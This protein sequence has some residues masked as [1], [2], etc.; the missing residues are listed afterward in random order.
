MQRVTHQGW[1]GASSAKRWL[2]ATG[3]LAL[4]VWAAPA[5][6]GEAVR[7]LVALVGD[8]QRTMF[9][10]R[11]LLREQ[12]DAAREALMRAVAAA[13]PRLLVILGDAVDKGDEES[14]WRYF[15]RVVAPVRERGTPIA[16][17]LGN[18]EYFG[19]VARMT[20]AVAARFAPFGPRSWNLVRSGPIAVVL[21]DSNF[22]HLASDAIREQQEWYETQL[23]KLAQD[24]AVKFI[25]VC[26]HHP[27]FTN[28]TVV[29]PSAE[30]ERRFLPPFLATPKAVLFA[31]GHCHSYE[32]FREQGKDLIVTGGGG[33]PRQRLTVDPQR[34]RFADLFVGPAIRP[35]HFCRL[36]VDGDQLVV[37]MVCLDAATGTWAVCDRFVASAATRP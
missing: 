18:H 15:D 2:A 22:E 3:V 11:L 30:V 19:N 31:S 13:D 25:V 32:H 23:A 24:E 9:G 35:F 28:S 36:D 33:G 8:T 14:A 26:C 21:L 20:A 17:V 4:L 7:P 27:P 16:A 1:V 34:R 5:L 29:S 37:T 12:N 6:G 10:E